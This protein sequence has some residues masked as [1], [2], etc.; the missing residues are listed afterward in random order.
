MRA[1]QYTIKREEKTVPDA[2]LLPNALISESKPWNW[3][4]SEPK[5]SKQQSP[6][7]G[8]KQKETQNPHGD[9]ISGYKNT[10]PQNEPNQS[11]PTKYNESKPNTARLN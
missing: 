8:N 11:P 7:Q 9:T 2:S 1:K 4:K 6:A 5:P 3:A 10:T